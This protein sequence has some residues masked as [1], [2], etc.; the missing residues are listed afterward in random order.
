MI[1]KK[2][3]INEGILYILS[4]FLQVILLCYIN[5]VANAMLTSNYSKVSRSGSVSTHHRPDDK[6]V[7][8]VTASQQNL[9]TSAKKLNHTELQPIQP[10]SSQ[11]EE[12]GPSTNKYVKIPQVQKL[13][14]LN[15]IPHFIIFERA[16]QRI[17]NRNR[18]NKPPFFPVHSFQISSRDDGPI[19]SDSDAPYESDTPPPDYQLGEDGLYY[20]KDTHPNEHYTNSPKEEDSMESYSGAAS[21]H[22]DSA[23]S[24]EHDVTGYK[25]LHHNPTQEYSISSDSHDLPKQEPSYQYSSPQ[26]DLY[27]MLEEDKHS[28]S[29]KDMHSL[30]YEA[31][32]DIPHANN[33]KPL[34]Q[35]DKE[36]NYPLRGMPH[37]S[38]ENSQTSQG[39]LYKNPCEPL[40]DSYQVQKDSC[41]PHIDSYEE[42]ISALNDT[43][44]TLI[45]KMQDATVKDSYGNP[46]SPETSYNIGLQ[47]EDNH[48]DLPTSGNIK[49][50]SAPSIIY[51]VPTMHSYGVPTKDMYR[52]QTTKNSHSTQVDSMYTVPFQDTYG[53]LPPS[54]PPTPK[55]SYGIPPK[56]TYGAP[57]EDIYGAPP[58]DSYGAP[59]EDTDGVPPKDIY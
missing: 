30:P 45:D 27:G 38:K 54:S 7:V 48:P 29:P 2:S 50:P 5:L 57:P 17:Y 3:D 36:V 12:T 4:D 33:G 22:P 19:H 13:E 46:L 44:K 53:K 55:D 18:F 23:S 58:K 28:I 43:F 34:S 24:A 21:Y 20:P 35:N 6:G 39:Q 52:E 31:T 9:P 26:K 16:Q 49:S 14:W 40:V 37:P 1:E 10:S 42:S 32:H 25:Y 11:T 56:D 59:P 51:G 15:I 47:S 8:I 41:A